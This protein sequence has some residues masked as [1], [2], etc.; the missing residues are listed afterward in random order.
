M[1]DYIEMHILFTNIVSFAEMHMCMY[2]DW[3][4]YADANTDADTDTDE[5]RSKSGL[6]F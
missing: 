4:H 6:L 5:V 3:Y 1:F 2:A